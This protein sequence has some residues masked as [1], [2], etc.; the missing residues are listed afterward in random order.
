[1]HSYRC[2]RCLRGH[3]LLC[4]KTLPTSRFCSAKETGQPPLSGRFAFPLRGVPPYILSGTNGTSGTAFTG[5]GF[6]RPGERDT[7]GQSG[8][9][10][11]QR[12]A[13]GFRSLAHS[14]AWPLFSGAKVAFGQPL[15]ANFSKAS[16][17]QNDS[18]DYRYREP[19]RLWF[20]DSLGG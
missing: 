12:S 3:V 1:M 4:W 17:G 13:T 10:K 9:G 15:P 20:A 7:T 14:P 5:A 2:P 11:P 16:T 8:T 18:N 19:A 6:S